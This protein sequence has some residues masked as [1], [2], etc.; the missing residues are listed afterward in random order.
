MIKLGLIGLGK[1]GCALAQRL[2]DAH[3]SIVGYDLSDVMRESARQQGIACVATLEELVSQCTIFWIMVPAGKAVD[4]VLAAL[5]ALCPPQTIIVDGGNSHFVDTIRRAENL[6]QRNIILL[7]CGTS[8]GVHGRELGFSL[9]VGGDYAAYSLLESIFKALAAPEGYAYM[10]VS[11]TGHYVKMVHNGIEYALL[12]AYAEGFQLLKEGHFKDLDLSA[13][14]DV[15]NHGSVIRSW[16]LHLMQEIV[17][18]E[19]PV[20]G[21]SGYIE[22]SGMGM[23][24]VEDAQEHN[25]PVKLIE[26]ALAIRAWSRATGG[27]FATKLV[28]LLRNKFGGH[29]VK[30]E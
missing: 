5:Q 25:V 8:G 28:A 20:E 26:D 17:V 10:G 23:W 2:R 1:M 19:N 27:N 15:W 22:E 16:I 14:A 4:A 21:V 11:G 18:Q 29:A 7:D 13:I 30:K 6:A 9:M 3:I 12:Q 24:T